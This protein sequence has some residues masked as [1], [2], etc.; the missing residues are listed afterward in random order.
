VAYDEDGKQG[1]VLFGTCA[2]A[3]KASVGAW[4]SPSK[5]SDMPNGRALSLSW[6]HLMLAPGV[7]MAP[8]HVNPAQRQLNR[9]ALPP[10]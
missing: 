6:W 10:A 1:L 2:S 4:H 8:Q 9:N 5:A 3:S 7:V